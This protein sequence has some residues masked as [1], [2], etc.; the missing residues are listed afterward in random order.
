MICENDRY[1]LPEEVLQMPREEIDAE[2]RKTFE[3]MMANPK[4]K[5]KP[6][7]RTNIKFNWE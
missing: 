7:F 4:K 2:I 5:P 1:E 3:E 6:S